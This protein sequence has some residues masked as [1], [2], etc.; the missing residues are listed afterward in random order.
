MKYSLI[1]PRVMRHS[2]FGYLRN[3]FVS[4][5]ISNSID[6][7]LASQIFCS[8]FKLTRSKNSVL[9]AREGVK[10]IRALVQ[11]GRSFSKY[12]SNLNDAVF[13]YISIVK[14]H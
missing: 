13:N 10:T 11:R 4:L 12:T 3:S 5:E 14:R 8:I 6:S 2:K 7:Y 9:F 1:D